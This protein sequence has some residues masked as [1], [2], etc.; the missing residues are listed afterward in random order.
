MTISPY[1]SEFWLAIFLHQRKVGTEENKFGLFAKVSYP[2]WLYSNGKIRLA[3][4]RE[5]VLAL[6]RPEITLCEGLN[7]CCIISWNHLKP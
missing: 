5:Y 1:F 4:L 3:W 7:H 6:N 2:N